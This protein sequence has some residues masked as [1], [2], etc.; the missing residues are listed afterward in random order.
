MD[1]KITF[2]ERSFNWL[3]EGVKNSPLKTIVIIIFAVVLLVH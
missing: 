1:D 3:I 2:Y